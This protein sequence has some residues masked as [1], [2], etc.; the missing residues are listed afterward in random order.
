MVISFFI[1]LHHLQETGRC[2]PGL[3]INI[4]KAQDEARRALYTAALQEPELS[5]LALAQ[6]V[7]SL[8]Y[9]LLCART[10]SLE[11]IFGPIEFAFCL[12]MQ[13]PDGR[14]RTANNLT[15]FLAAMQ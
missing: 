13:Q 6:M 9:P 11:K 3:V 8:C 4:T 10:S 12:Y 2:P 14:Y 15:Q 5:D 1:R 7:H